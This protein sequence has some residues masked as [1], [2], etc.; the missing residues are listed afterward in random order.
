MAEQFS[1]LFSP[2]TIGP[3]TVRNRIVS[4]SHHPLFLSRETF[5]HDDRMIA[6]WAEKA[7]GG[8]GIIESYLTTLHC[9]PEQDV[10]RFPAAE[11]AFA[12]AAETIHSHGAKFICQIANSGAQSGVSG[13]LWGMRLRR[14]RRRMARDISMFP[15]K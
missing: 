2:I 5:L 13:N 9:R 7:K 6:Y 12:K 1:T 11:E 15:M 10:F 4:S 14:Y 8:V 3:M